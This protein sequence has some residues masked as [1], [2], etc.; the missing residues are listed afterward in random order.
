MALARTPAHDSSS[1]SDISAFSA[2]ITGTVIQPDD[3]GYDVARLVKNRNHDRYP[4]LIVRAAGTADV[5]R[6]VLF[7]RDAGL[8]LAVR[9]GSHSLAGYGTS[10]GGIVLD[11]SGMKGLHIDP[12]RRLAGRRRA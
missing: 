10:D 4:A 8:E 9:G 1:P 11:L 3:E 12:E 5:I 7:A 2:G 6:T